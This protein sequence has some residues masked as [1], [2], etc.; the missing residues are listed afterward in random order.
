MTK[1]AWHSY[2]K[3]AWGSEA[4]KPLTKSAYIDPTNQKSGRTI[5]AAM[6]TLWVMGLTEEYQL[7]RAW[8]EANLSF[9]R[10]VHRMYSDIFE[11]LHS[12]QNKT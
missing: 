4:L 9:T 8:I 10:N 11:R 6:T 3:Y 1:E 7:G 12:V 5:M 2:V